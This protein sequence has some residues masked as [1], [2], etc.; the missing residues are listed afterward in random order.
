MKNL[1]KILVFYCLC[2]CTL[3]RC[4]SKKKDVVII[5]YYLSIEAKKNH[6]NWGVFVGHIR[7]NSPREDSMIGVNYLL[8][9]DVNL[10]STSIKQ[11]VF[12]FIDTSKFTFPIPDSG[13][14]YITFYKTST[15]TKKDIIPD[16]YNTSLNDDE[17]ARVDCQDKIWGL[18]IH[19]NQGIYSYGL[20]FDIKKQKV[21]SIMSGPF[22]HGNAGP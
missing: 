11:Y 4:S 13:S 5:P 21:L 15:T 8:E 19:S 7:S 16:A 20:N 2:I 22:G 9:G 10:D 18:T 17:I 3:L 1:L 6:L 14:L 12:N